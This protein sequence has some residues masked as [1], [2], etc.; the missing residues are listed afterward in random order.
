MRVGIR[1]SGNPK[2]EHE[3]H[4]RFDP[5]PLF[6]LQGV[7]LVSLQKDPTAPVPNHV[8]VPSLATWEETRDVISG[9]DLVIT[10]C[11]SVAHLSGAM[12]VPT[13][14]IVPILAY[15]LWALPGDD[16]PWYNSMR[17][18]RQERAGDWD[19]PFDRIHQDLR[20]L[21]P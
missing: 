4:R 18:Y 17:L 21:N 14:T 12:G 1:W 19:A 9:L 11:T 13:W 16:T 3:Q 7:E 15:Y 2:F 5:A 20:S 8:T 6:A 10:S